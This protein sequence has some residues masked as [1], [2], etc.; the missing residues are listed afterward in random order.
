MRKWMLALALAAGSMGLLAG[1]LNELRFITEE[2]AS[3]N[4]V[5]EG[6]PHGPAVELLLAATRHAGSP[7]TRAQIEVLPWA[8]GFRSAK[9]G[10]H[11]VL[12]ST[13][14]TPE[15]EAHFQWVGPIGQE[16]D[17][18]IGRKVHA[19]SFTHPQDFHKYVIGALRDDAAAEHLRAVGLPDENLVLATQVNH[20][21]KMLHAGRIDLWAFGEGGWLHVLETTGLDERLFEVVHHFPSRDYYFA[22]SLDVAPALVAQLQTAVDAV[23]REH[24][25]IYKLGLSHQSSTPSSP[26]TAVTPATTSE[27]IT[28]GTHHELD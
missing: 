8:R 3:L 22:L 14:R 18:L 4:Y 2:S 9:Q 5:F 17:V 1:E 7:M 24:G 11:A 27:I 13:L 6:K 25:D 16:R 28:K 12:F 26:T 19:F 15:R 20:L 21:A 23:L 10:P